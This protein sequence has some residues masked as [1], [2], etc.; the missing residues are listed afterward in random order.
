MHGE[1]L[2]NLSI[3]RGA[4]SFGAVIKDHTGAILLQQ[5][6]V[7]GKGRAMSNNVEEYAGVLH[8][9]KYLRSRPPGRVTIYGDS[10]LVINQLNGRWRIKK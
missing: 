10:N 4:A 1:V 7:V 5:H 8:V 2:A 6:R 3:P 9:L